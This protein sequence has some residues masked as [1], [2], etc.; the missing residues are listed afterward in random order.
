MTAMAQERGAPTS[1]TGFGNLPID[2]ECIR[3]GLVAALELPQSTTTREAINTNTRQVR[4]HLNLL[5]GE[6]SGYDSDN[7]VRDLFRQAYALLSSGRRPDAATPAFEAFE[8]LRDA[9]RVTQHFLDV[10]EN[11]RKAPVHRPDSTPLSARSPE[12]RRTTTKEKP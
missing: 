7:A 2:V 9:A 8:Y 1:N 12:S 10:F 6:E 4:G 3:D 11:F 5:M